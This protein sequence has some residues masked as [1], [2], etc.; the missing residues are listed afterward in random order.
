MGA[1]SGARHQALSRHL[2]QQRENVAGAGKHVAPNVSNQSCYTNAWAP[3]SDTVRFVGSTKAKENAANLSTSR[4]S[5]IQVYLMR[6]TARR[7]ESCR[8]RSSAM[9]HAFFG[10]T[11]GTKQCH[12]LLVGLGQQRFRMNAVIFIVFIG[13]AG[14]GS[15][16]S[17]WVAQ[18]VL[19][20]ETQTTYLPQ[21]R[22]RGLEARSRAA[23]YRRRPN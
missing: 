14:P 16:V 23:K 21:S 11:T 6:Y 19:A 5:T 8:Y 7:N 20:A 1:T 22:K 18:H 9:G 3:G 12:Y 10:P 13:L 17:E 4:N 2:P 15:I